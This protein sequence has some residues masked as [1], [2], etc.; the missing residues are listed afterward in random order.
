MGTTKMIFPFYKNVVYFIKI[1]KQNA[2]TEYILNML[3]KTFDVEKIKEIEFYGENALN[4]TSYEVIII[5][6]KNKWI[7]SRSSNS[8]IDTM[9]YKVIPIQELY[10]ILIRDEIRIYDSEENDSLNIK[11]TL[12]EDEDGNIIG[13]NVYLSDKLDFNNDNKFEVGDR[14]WSYTYQQWGIISSISHK[15]CVKFTDMDGVFDF[16]MDG[17]ILAKARVIDLTKTQKLPLKD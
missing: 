2:N 3:K 5:E 1:N 14:V 11:Q 6:Y 13:V 8:L 12:S 9:G 16:R 7:I 10:S 17:K 15:I 4:N